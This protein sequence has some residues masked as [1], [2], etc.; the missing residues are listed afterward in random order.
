MWMLC[1]KAQLIFAVM[2]TRDTEAKK[3]MNQNQTP[4]PHTNT[5][6]NQT[7]APQPAKSSML[8]EQ[9]GYGVMEEVMWVA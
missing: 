1:E 4:P 7:K 2:K 9:C 8:K 3:Q 5:H 6:K